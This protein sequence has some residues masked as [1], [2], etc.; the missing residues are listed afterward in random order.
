M[1][2]SLKTKIW[3]TVLSV[4]LMF[5]F[6]SLYYFPRQQGQLLLQ[7]YNSEVQNLANTVSLGV[8]IALTEQNFEGVQTAMEFVK[9]DPRLQ[10]IAL[11]QEDTTW[12]QNHTSYMLK[13]S[14]FKTFPDKVKV[15]PNLTSNAD[16]VVKRSPFH[17]SLL[18]GYI[19][20]GF[21]TKGIIEN[22]KRIRNTSLMVSGIVLLIGILISFMLAKNISIPLLALRDAALRVGKGD[23]MQRV[24]I[25]TSDEIEELGNAFNKMVDD[26]SKT[27]KELRDVN[28]SLSST[29]ETL[30]TTLDELKAT[31]AQLIQNEKMA[32][33]GELTAG[34]AHEIQNP[35]NFVKNFAEVNMELIN[36][37]KEDLQ[38]GNLKETVSILNDV[39]NNNEKVIHHCHRADGIVKGMLQHSRMSTGQK[40]PIKINSFVDEYLRLAY[41]GL[42]AKDK[43]FNTSIQTNFDES[44][45]MV[46]IVPQDFGRVLLNLFNNAF[47]AVMERKEAE[48]AEYNPTVIVTTK[49]VSA[50]LFGAKS[51]PSEEQGIEI[52]VSDNGNGIPQN[53]I[54]KIFHPF[55]T[56]KP[57]G[58]GTGL[59]LSLSYDIIKA[60]GGEIKVNSK[61]GEGA[62]FIIRLPKL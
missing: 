40:E 49:R 55:F 36:E 24:Q 62:E 43:T 31:Q 60:H 17:T 3:L 35:L 50:N 1:Y 51:S 11:V 37:I 44:V 13:H 15:A 5:S 52:I 58:Q 6:F 59:G 18:S 32:S 20:L 33:L 16:L 41:H 19:L 10:F 8:K 23:L 12:Q 9:D 57:T 27:R 2:I 25:K 39:V 28:A 61:E 22:E 42:R 29:N 48:D 56:T 14:V 30:H 54:T 46:N 45:G 34:I 21:T 38:A 4:V 53:I 26:L 47:Y 7:N